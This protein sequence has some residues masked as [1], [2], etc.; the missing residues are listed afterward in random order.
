MESASIAQYVCAGIG[1]DLTPDRP[2]T[3][4][5][6]HSADD[7]I[8]PGDGLTTEGQDLLNAL[9][10]FAAALVRST[11][12]QRTERQVPGHLTQL[13]GVTSQRGSSAMSGDADG[14]DVTELVISGDI[15]L[16]NSDFIATGEC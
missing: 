1:T 3:D 10:R 2:I 4:D 15:E 6:S 16:L 7:S 9:K 14:L 12:D 8:C 13:H 11:S 5:L